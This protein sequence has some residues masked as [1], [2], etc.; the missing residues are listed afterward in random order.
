MNISSCR[1]LLVKSSRDLLEAWRETEV[2]WRDAKSH[3]FYKEFISPI[4]KS[5]ASAGNV[6]QELGGI[7]TKIRRDCE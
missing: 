6:I 5:V 7:L 4:P 1:S 3:Q 2:Y